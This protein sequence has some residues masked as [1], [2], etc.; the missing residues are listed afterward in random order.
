VSLRA[1]RRW[2]PRAALLALAALAAAAPAGAQLAL[3]SD[4]RA[5]SVDVTVSE[6][7][8]ASCPPLITPGCLPDSTTTNSYPDS[9]S[10]SSGAPFSAT[11]GAL[12][13]F[14]S[15]DSQLSATGI[16]GSGSHAASAS[17]Y[18]TGGFPITFHSENHEAESRLVVEFAL[19]EATPYTL[20]GSVATGGAIFSLSSSHIRLSGPGGTVAEVQVDSDPNCVD[21]S[22]FQVGPVPLASS[23]TLAA[24]TYTLEALAG[25][26]ASGVHS[27]S[28]SFG[29]GVDGSFEVDLALTVAVPSLAP[30]GL[31]L[32]ALA[33][34][35]AAAAGR[36]RGAPAGRR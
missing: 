27:T 7:Y 24:G 14:A 18:N 23:G 26:T 32:L 13:S 17:F 31:A 11:A 29:T 15:Q 21:P 34:V 2:L 9:E 12:G 6:Y 33:L 30:A 20:S 3:V 4:D 36:G 25:G 8:F 5:V 22:C 35:A 10:A 16:S 28:G 19:A 1:P